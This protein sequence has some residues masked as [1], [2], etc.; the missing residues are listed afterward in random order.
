MKV[1]VQMGSKQL[2]NP[3]RPRFCLALQ[4]ALKSAQRAN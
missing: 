4:A 1:M 2:P 3:C